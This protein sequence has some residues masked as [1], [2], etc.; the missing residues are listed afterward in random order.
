MDQ[1]SCSILSIASRSDLV[2]R[3][4]SS[5]LPT[6]H[7]SYSGCMATPGCLG[8]DTRTNLDHPKDAP[9]DAPKGNSREASIGS[10]PGGRLLGIRPLATHSLRGTG[11]AT[12]N[13]RVSEHVEQRASIHPLSDRGRVR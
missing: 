13:L 11:N 8:I 3:S 1:V 9:K 4:V 12:E 2:G 6:P 5:D 7:V 10:R